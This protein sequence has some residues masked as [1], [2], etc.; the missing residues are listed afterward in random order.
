MSI[1]LPMNMSVD[2]IAIKTHFLG[3]RFH[4]IPQTNVNAIAIY[5]CVK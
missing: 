3:V 2:Y 4:I 1:A 5:I